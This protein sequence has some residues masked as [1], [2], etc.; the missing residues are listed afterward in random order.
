MGVSSW[1]GAGL[2][3]PPACPASATGLSLWGGVSSSQRQVG[4]S[5]LGLS[6][7]LSS[8]TPGPVA[9]L[10]GQLDSAPLGA[11]GCICGGGRAT[12]P[13]RGWCWA[14][15]GPAAVTLGLGE[16]QLAGAWGGHA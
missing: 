6:A 9:S 16:E 2:L 1:S 10:V 5:F 3:S 12:L 11:G 13:P 8:L 15:R 7:S 14:L 4:L